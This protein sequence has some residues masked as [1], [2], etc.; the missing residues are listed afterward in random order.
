MSFIRQGFGLFSALMIFASSNLKAQNQTSIPVQNVAPSVSS[1]EKP[2]ETAGKLTVNIYGRQ[3]EDELSRNHQGVT[4]I[5]PEAKVKYGDRITLGV[6][7]AVQMGSGNASNFW[8]DDGVTANTFILFEAYGKLN[9]HK[10]IFIKAGAVKTPINPVSTIMSRGTFF[11][12]QESW[13]VG[14]DNSNI[15]LSAYQAVPSAGIVSRRIYDDGTQ[16]YFLSQTL[17]G[18]LKSEITGTEFKAAATR[19]QFENLST[20]V[21]NDCYFLGNSLSAFEGSSKSFRFRHG[22]MGTESSAALNQE[23]GK[24]EVFFTVSSIIN[25]QAPSGKNQG[26]LAGGGFKLINGNYAIKPSYYAFDYDA[27]VTPTTYTLMTN[28]YQNRKGYR[29]DVAIELK[30]EKLALISTY[31]KMDLKDENPYL[32]DREIYNIALEAKYDIF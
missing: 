28:R 30:K 29:A 24:H 16:A 3:V 11:G 26:R 10:N 22:F 25:D 18:K 14:A 32:A 4:T 15:T 6:D 19:F 27:D 7:F 9:L 1:E 8:N 23:V 31:L 17:G 21:A 20:N 2:F 12:V 13:Q 5:N